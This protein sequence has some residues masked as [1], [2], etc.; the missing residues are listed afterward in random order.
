MKKILFHII[1][2][3]FCI[4]KYLALITPN[5]AMITP[6]ERMKH[7]DLIWKIREEIDTC[8]VS[9]DEICGEVCKICHGDGFLPCRFCGGTGFLMLG[10]ELIGTNNNC[11]VC[12][13]SGNE[14][15]KLCMGAG[16]IVKWREDYDK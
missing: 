11:T 4:K 2:Y 16:Y 8:N 3:L 5:L 10:H 15:C 13:G 6:L 7:L 12:K 1:F 9:K 14:E